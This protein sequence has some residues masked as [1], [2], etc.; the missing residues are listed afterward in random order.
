MRGDCT[1]LDVGDL[2]RRTAEVQVQAELWSDAA[3]DLQVEAEAELRS[4]TGGNLQVQAE[5][6]VSTRHP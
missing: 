3:G 6:E 1:L 5:A 2:G 4:A